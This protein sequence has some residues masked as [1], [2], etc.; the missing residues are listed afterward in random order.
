VAN[1]L[2]FEDDLD[3]VLSRESGK[4]VGEYQI[5]LES[6]RFDNYNVSFVGA[7]YKIAPKAIKIVANDASKVYGMSDELSCTVVGAIDENV[8]VVSRQAGES[9]GTYAIDSYTLLNS[10]YVV[11]EFEAGVFEITKAMISVEILG[12]SKVYGEA[13]DIA[14]EISNAVE[15]LDV[16]ILREAGEN[17]GEYVIHGFEINNKNYK[18]VEFKTAKFIIEKA[19]ITIKIADAT[20]VYGDIDPI[21]SYSV[22]GLAF[23]DVI[24]LNITREEGEN[25]GEYEISCGD[26]MFDNYA[27]E[28][29][30]LGK[31]EI[32]KA[33]YPY[34]LKDFTV[35]YNGNAVSLQVFDFE[36]EFEF[37]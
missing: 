31:L 16:K 7:K 9:V 26:V 25:A 27:V 3:I 1:G 8:V 21:F 24:N 20:K 28:S 32:C 37:S 33:D 23:D 19:P 5:S 4:V 14:Y 6:G 18:V 22:E 15:E 36:Y 13:D 35:I 17:A 30:V 29:V 11:E 2:A 10:N 34:T 12:A